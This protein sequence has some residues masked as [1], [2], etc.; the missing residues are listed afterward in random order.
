MIEFIRPWALLALPLPFLAWRL[1]PALPVPSAV[2]VPAGV[3]DLLQGLNRAG[4]RR[5]LRWSAGLGLRALGWTALVI[6]LA[7]PFTRGQILASP[8]GR[9]LVVAVDL[10]A[11]MDEDDMKLDGETM[12]RYQ[13][14][15]DLIGKFIAERRGD[16]V[17]LIVFGQEAHLIAPLTFDTGAVAAMLDE[18]VIGLSG[19]RTDLGRA[20][21][22]TVQV[23]RHEPKATRVLVLLSDGEDNSGALTGLD[24]AQIAAAHDVKIYTIGFTAE[25][26]ADGADNLR[27]LAEVTGGVFYPAQSAAALAEISKMLDQVEPSA[28]EADQTRLI[29]EWTAVPLGL[30]FLVLVGL[31]VT[32]RRDA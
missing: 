24:A 30:A 18:L 8:T 29:R 3:R 23:L 7:G 15:R 31:V 26:N 13:V 28:I 27:T 12:A 32:R 14:V 16:R 22:L 25:L 21:G 1:L 6:A 19:H 4:H 5:A 9:D 20:I 2:P 10:S 11:S 17:A